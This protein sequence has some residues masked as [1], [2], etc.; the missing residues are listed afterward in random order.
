MTVASQ[1]AAMDAQAQRLLADLEPIIERVRSVAARQ[2]VEGAI[3]DQVVRELREGG[4][5]RVLQP[6]RWGGYEMHPAV[7]SSLQTRLGEADLS[8]AWVYGVMG[9]H[10]FQ[11]GLFDDRAA[12]DVWGEDSSKLISS[13]YQPGGIATPVA[14]GYRFNGNWKFSSGIKHAQWVFLGGIHEGEFL[15]CLVPR[16]D[17]EV[18]ETWDVFGLKATGSQDVIVKDIFVPEYRVHKVSD[19]FR[20]DS[21]GNAVNTAPLYRI[22][23]P[24]IFIR[25][26]TTG[27]IGALRGMLQ[28]FQGY[29]EKRV[30]SVGGATREDPDAQAVCAE[31][32]AELDEMEHI[33][34]RN[35]DE[36][37]QHARSGEPP[38]IDRRLI[39]KYQ[40]AAVPERCLRLANRLFKCTGGS[41]IFAQLPF[42][43]Y[44]R[45]II[46]ARQHAASQNQ[47][48]A[49]SWGGVI[50][51]KDN[52]EWYL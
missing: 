27:A 45:D 25:A 42:G 32:V 24:Q 48:V 11:M 49:R 29:A 7:F 10:N 40:A 30:A 20:C 14:G 28:A 13:T 44:Y 38:P 50:L 33:L 39:F 3:D 16:E 31:I 34:R 15:T 21:P 22:P 35:Y 6:K 2:E 19:G 5:F 4:F 26:I 51:G 9:C 18:V 41:G 37:L 46:T 52:Q 8:T 12:Q 1:H 36:L 23:F 43:R 17:Y 47:V